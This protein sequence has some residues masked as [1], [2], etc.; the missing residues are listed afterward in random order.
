MKKNIRLLA[1]A[2]L[3]LPALALAGPA[4]YVRTP[5]VEY[6]ERELDI[7]YGTER[8]KD[9]AG[10]ERESAGAIGLGYGATQWWFTEAYVKYEKDASEKTK[11]D[12]FEWEN[13]FQ[14]TEH[15][16]YFFDL[17]L[18]TEIE[19]PRER[20]SEGYEIAFGPLVQF[21]TGPLRWNTNVFFEKVVRSHEEGPHPTEIGYQI[22][23][24]YRLPAGFDVGVQ[25]FGEMG[26]WNDWE[27]RDEQKHRI[28]PAVFGKVKLEG[29][30]AI[31][32]NAAFL[33]GETPATPHR[34][35]RLQAEYEF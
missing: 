8:M 28:G 7:K 15:N 35:F 23:A 21:D 1:A 29:R 22:Q 24:A 12:A 9:S 20:K 13:K 32:Y 17:G 33:L 14:L 3:G 16:K 4:D 11:Y 26:K 25:A 34:T 19:I 5:G 10:G 30:Q 31:R 6:G 18:F 2:A 27:A